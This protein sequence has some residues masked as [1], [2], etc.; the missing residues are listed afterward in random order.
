MR[1]LLWIFGPLYLLVFIQQVVE[2]PNLDLL[3]R[4]DLLQPSIG[5]L[6]FHLLILD[7][8]NSIEAQQRLITIIE[9]QRL[10]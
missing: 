2:V 6:E 1:I 4:I 8:H 9:V 3:L 10:V 7:Q 5:S